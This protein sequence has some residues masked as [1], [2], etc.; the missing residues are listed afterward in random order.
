MVLILD[1]NLEIGAHVST[2]TGYFRTKTF[3]SQILNL[4]QKR[5][6]FLP[7]C[8]KRLKLPSNISTMDSTLPISLGIVVHISRDII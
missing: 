5:L 2:E 8:V 6:G 7:K 4:L 3:Q 1:G